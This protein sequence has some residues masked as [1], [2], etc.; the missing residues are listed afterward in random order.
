MEIG[1]TI[2]NGALARF[3]TRIETLPTKGNGKLMDGMAQAHNTFRMVLSSIVVTF[4]AINH[5]V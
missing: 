4:G 5:M 1:K 3:T 2:R